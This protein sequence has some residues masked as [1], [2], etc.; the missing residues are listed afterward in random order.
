M[1]DKTKKIT[2]NNIKNKDLTKDITEKDIIEVVE[3]IVN[4]KQGTREH[5]FHLYRMFNLPIQTCAALSGYNENYGYRLS[6]K[7]QNDANVRHRVE[8]II[9]DMPEAYRNVCKLRLIKVSE[10]EG[11]ALQ[12]YDDD[13]V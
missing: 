3:N 5:K 12:E 7:Y 8:K 1:N 4:T 6:K 10:I 13:P 9:S 2:N 11:K